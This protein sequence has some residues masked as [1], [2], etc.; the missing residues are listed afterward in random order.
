MEM[1][2]FKVHRKCIGGVYLFGTKFDSHDARI[3]VELD[4]DQSRSIDEGVMISRPYLRV[5]SNANEE[6][7]P[8]AYSDGFRSMLRV[9]LSGHHRNTTHTNP[10]SRT[11]NNLNNAFILTKSHTPYHITSPH[12]LPC[13]KLHYHQHTSHTG[14]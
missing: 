5:V 3:L 6:N 2:V 12:K 1:Y 13:F 4:S 9:N 8:C 10:T 11:S 7:D 14:I